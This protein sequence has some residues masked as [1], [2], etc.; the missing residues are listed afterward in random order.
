M[1]YTPSLNRLDLQSLVWELRFAPLIDCIQIK[2]EGQIPPTQLPCGVTIRM[3]DMV[4]LTGL[5]P[6]KVV[7]LRYPEVRYVGSERTVCKILV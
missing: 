7:T 4:S 2:E 1:D 3:D 6:K 5:I